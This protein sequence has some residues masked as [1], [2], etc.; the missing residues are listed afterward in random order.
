MTLSALTNWI[1]PIETISGVAFDEFFTYL[2]AILEDNGSGDIYFQ[3]LSKSESHF[4]SEK[5]IAFRDGANVAV[6]SQG[7]RRTWVMRSTNGQMIDLQ[8][9]TSNVPA[10]ALY[11]R[12]QFTKTGEIPEMFVLDGRPF[13]YT[14]MAKSLHQTA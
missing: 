12:A 1:N 6:R 5:E 8:V 3:P 13:S 7:W 4:P 9:L 10:V 11:G 2:N 14:F